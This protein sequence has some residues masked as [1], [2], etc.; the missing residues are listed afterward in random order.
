MTIIS[1]SA[2]YGVMQLLDPGHPPPQ[3]SIFGAHARAH[4]WMA[5]GKA[6]VSF[7][8]WTPKRQHLSPCILISW[9]KDLAP[10]SCGDQA[11]QCVQ[12][13]PHL[14]YAKFLWTKQHRMGYCGLNSM[15]STISAANVLERT[16][17]CSP[18]SGVCLRAPVP[19][20]T[21][22]H[23]AK[24]W[25]NC[26]HIVWNENQFIQDVLVSTILLWQI[27]NLTR[28]VKYIK[29]CFLGFIDRL[30]WH[31][32]WTLRSLRYDSKND[33]IDNR[34]ERHHHCCCP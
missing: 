15:V 34:I 28:A 17:F 10:N 16:Q 24:S 2:I 30:L 27:K 19:L 11:T 18:L 1:V 4:T 14:F 32:S 6:W 8:F 33:W 12:L 5:Q 3:V 31:D 25:N 22:H 20:S 13:V 9:G 29:A 21:D 23:P 26:W 7:W